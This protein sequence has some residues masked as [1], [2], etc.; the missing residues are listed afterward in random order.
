MSNDKPM[1]GDNTLKWEKHGREIFIRNIKSSRSQL[2]G[3]KRLNP[4]NFHQM[5]ILH[6]LRFPTYGVLGSGLAVEGCLV[7]ERWLG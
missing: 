4:L 2:P 3:V 5:S 1:I 7:S 6:C